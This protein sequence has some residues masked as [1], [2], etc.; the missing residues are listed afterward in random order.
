MI[1]LSTLSLSSAPGAFSG[2]IVLVSNH[3]VALRDI[4]CWG[5]ETRRK[6]EERGRE[7]KSRC[8]EGFRLSRGELD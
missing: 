7:G 1:P 3:D 5:F 4:Y 6:V 2:M 8:D